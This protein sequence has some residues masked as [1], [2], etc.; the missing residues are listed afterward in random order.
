ML[1]KP[2]GAVGL[3]APLGWQLPAAASAVRCIC[4]RPAEGARPRSR[5]SPA[6]LPWGVAQPSVASAAWLVPPPFQRKPRRMRSA[7]PP[8]AVLSVPGVDAC[9]VGPV[10]LSHALGLA[11]SLGFPACFDSP[12]FKVGWAAGGRSWPALPGP[13]LQA[14]SV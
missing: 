1:R 14:V 13:A 6:R 12:Q 7:P 3:R 5:S 2:G 8:Q 9:F 4:T 11:Q 10:D